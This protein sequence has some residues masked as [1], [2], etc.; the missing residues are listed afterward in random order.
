LHGVLNMT[1]CTTICPREFYDKVYESQVPAKHEWVA[2]T[3]SPELIKL[4]WDGVIKPRDKIL[5]IG[6]GVG[7]ESVFLA[8]R[9]MDVTGIDLSGVAIKLGKQLADFYGVNVS[10]KQMDAL[11]L[12]FSKNIFDVVTDQGVFH[13][14]RDEERNDYAQQIAK[15]LKPGGLF[16][17]RGFSDKMNYNKPQPRLLTS[18]EIINTFLP[19]FNLEH[20]ERVLTF[21][22][23]TRKKPIAWFTVWYKKTEILK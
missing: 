15:V 13:H 8:I 17:M 11:N 10:F 22:T 14:L 12:Q 21:S 23:E 3:A 5:E 7:T 6:T 18:S 4:V 16:I 9:G 2:G 19:Y 20:M 1:E